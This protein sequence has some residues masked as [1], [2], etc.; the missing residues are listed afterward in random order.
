MSLALLILAAMITSA[1]LVAGIN[2]FLP[3]VAFKAAAIESPISH[4]VSAQLKPEETARNDWATAYPIAIVDYGFDN[5]SFFLTMKNTFDYTELGTRQTTYDYSETPYSLIT[6][7][8][9]GGLKSELYNRSY[10]HKMYAIG[11]TYSVE[12]YKPIQI[13]ENQQV[14]VRFLFENNTSP[15]LNNSGTGKFETSFFVFSL[16]QQGEGVLQQVGGP[17]V[18]TCKEIPEILSTVK[19]IDYSYEKDGSEMKGLLPGN[20]FAEKTSTIIPSI[21]FTFGTGFVS[22]MY[23]E[24]ISGNHLLKMNLSRFATACKDGATTRYYYTGDEI[25]ARK[26]MPECVQFECKYVTFNYKPKES[27][28]F[29]FLAEAKYNNQTELFE[30]NWDTAKVSNGEYAISASGRYRQSSQETE[31]DAIA[32]TY[33]EYVTV[34]N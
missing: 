9:L 31:S 29:S 32:G 27:S 12:M 1:L 23:K 3:S 33:F 20:K 13:N 21:N 30:A 2:F 15:C 14:T 22:P 10:Y 19:K 11:P 7:I 34:E 8:E 28:N 6:S 17:F 5:I 26:N 4:V 18:G 24:K 25:N 16:Y